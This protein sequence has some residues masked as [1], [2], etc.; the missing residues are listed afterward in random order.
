MGGVAWPGP[1]YEDR[2]SYWYG[3]PSVIPGVT[4][5]RKLLHAYMITPHTS[6]THQSHVRDV[7][8]ACSRIKHQTNT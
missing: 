5:E 8:H 3:K 2:L 7:L 1:N 6:L 4:S